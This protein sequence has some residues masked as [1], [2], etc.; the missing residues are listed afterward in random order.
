MFDCACLYVEII[1]CCR[2]VKNIHPSNEHALDT[3]MSEP[4]VGSSG[5][6]GG[7]VMGVDYSDCQSS[8]VTPLGSAVIRD[9]HYRY[10]EEED[11]EE[12]DEKDEELEVFFGG[13]DGTS[14]TDL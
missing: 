13:E 3:E 8:A 1:D 11:D 10:E 6:G 4:L 2:Y 12:E 7:A 5:T 9:R 14:S